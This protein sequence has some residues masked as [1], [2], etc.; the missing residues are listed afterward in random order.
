MF[1]FVQDEPVT[2]VDEFSKLQN[3]LKNVIDQQYKRGMDEIQLW[4]NMPVLSDFR[5][6]IGKG[7][8]IARNR[9]A[10]RVQKASQEALASLSN[11][12]QSNLPQAIQ[13]AR[14][15]FESKIKTPLQNYLR[16]LNGIGVGE[17]NQLME[18]GK[19]LQPSISNIKNEISNLRHQMH[20][21][22]MLERRAVP[23]LTEM[24][25][26]DIEGNIDDTIS[27][28]QSVGN[29]MGQRLIS[30]LQTLPNYLDLGMNQGSGLLESARSIGKQ[31]RQQGYDQIQSL[32]DMIMGGRRQLGNG[33][34]MSSQLNRESTRRR[35]RS[36]SSTGNSF[37]ANNRQN[38][39]EIDS[40]VDFEAQ[41]LQRRSISEPELDMKELDEIVSPQMLK[42]QD[43]MAMTDDEN[44]KWFEDASDFDENFV[45]E[46]R[47][48]QQ[49]VSDIGNEFNQKYSSNLK[50]TMM[51][52]TKNL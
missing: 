8:N 13:N 40:R 43:L 24:M 19:N 3:R 20:P 16:A 18:M 31:M 34:E 26:E 32:S 23:G 14:R 46:G 35:G 22:T 50:S 25:K 38:N 41:N 11:V 12:D 45:D 36:S 27:P 2:T 28:V 48:Q 4:E 9:L 49:Q 17:N 21:P 42:E 39:E 51:E 33:N 52:P 44:E 30:R 5:E 1:R 7:F 15:S 6:R 47:R 29:K 10:D 37:R